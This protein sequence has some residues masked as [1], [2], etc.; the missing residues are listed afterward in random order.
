MQA[1]HITAFQ[2][3]ISSLHPTSVPH[4]PAPAHDEALI[5]I[6][7][8]ALNHVDILYA[9][10][11]HQNNTSLVRPPF[12]L[13]LE[14]AGTIIAL[15]T[16]NSVP[17]AAN[18]AETAGR[19][20]SD[21]HEETAEEDATRF[22]V[23]DRVFGASLGAYAERIVVPLR[24]LHHVPRS[25]T[26]E[27]AA[28]LAATASVAYGAL[29]IRAGVR[30]GDWVLVHGAAGGIGVYAC[31]IAKALGAK[32]IAGVRRSGETEKLAAL[33]RLG[34]VDGVVETGPSSD[35]GGWEK[36][37]MKLTAGKG[38]DVVVDNVG[39]VKESLRC[40]RPIGGKIILVGFAGRGGVMEQV[41]VNRI[42][43]RQAV[44]MGY[45]Y[46]D[47]DRKNPQETQDIWT[48]LMA[49]IAKGLVKPIIFEKKYHGLENVRTA[50]EDLQARKVYGKAVIR[51]KGATNTTKAAL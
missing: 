47:T 20:G 50:M 26:F 4:P 21:G 14:F 29:A 15:G 19:G 51:V 24:S 41:S 13:G 10:G 48:G 27:D 1:I 45:R 49:L 11:K 6:H 28:G 34:C 23:G 46:G 33:R 44:V 25:W 37:V 31:Q 30:T 32:V 22:R 39:L 8:A 12:T 40:L 38:V 5:E 35:K 36:E 16:S 18:V 9:Q 3:S 42:L 7:C 43:L 17:A 2:P